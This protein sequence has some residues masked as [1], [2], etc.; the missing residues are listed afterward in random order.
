VPREI[1]IPQ[2]DR[3]YRDEAY[4][5]TL[6]GNGHVSSF[7]DLDGFY[8]VSLTDLNLAN[9]TSNATIHSRRED[10]SSTQIADGCYEGYP[11]LTSLGLTGNLASIQLTTGV[12]IMTVESSG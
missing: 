5:T 11:V 4:V 12:H 1:V 8:E 7:R 10:L 2:F 9:G 6:F 3:H